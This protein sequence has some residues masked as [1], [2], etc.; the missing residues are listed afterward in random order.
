MDKDRLKGKAEEVK[1]KVKEKAGEW[2]GDRETQAEGRMDQGKGK[3]RNAIGKVKDAGRDAA[4]KL[5]EKNKPEIR[6]R[7]TSREVRDDGTRE[8]VI[9]HDEDAA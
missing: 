4:D 1:G 6:E 5:K 9:E 7:E 3:L 2:S 8:E